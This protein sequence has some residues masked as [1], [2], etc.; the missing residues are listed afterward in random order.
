MATRYW[1]YRVADDEQVADP[2]ETERAA[3]ACVRALEAETGDDY[4]YRAHP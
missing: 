4:D 3:T 2:F 1:V